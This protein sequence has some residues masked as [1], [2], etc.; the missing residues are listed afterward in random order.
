[1]KK[2]QLIIKKYIYRLM[3]LLAGITLLGVF[4][5]K[6]ELE[7]SVYR[8]SEI[9]M[10]DEYMEV[11]ANGLTDFLSLVDKA[12]YRGMLHAYGTYTCFVPT[13]NAVQEF[14]REKGISLESISEEEA[15]AF[16]GIHVVNDTLATSDFVDGRLISAT[17]RNQYLTV[18]TKNDTSG[19]VYIE[20][21]RQARIIEK[22]ISLGNGYIHVV[23][24]VLEESIQTVWETIKSLPDVEFSIMKELIRDTG[25]DKVLSQSGDSVFYSYFLQCNEVF[26]ELGV[27]TRSALLERLQENTPDITDNDA[28][29][30]NFVQYHC[31]PERK[32]VTD[33]LYASAFSTYGSN[34]VLTFNLDGDNIL[35]NEFKIGELDEDGVPVDRNSIYTDLT[36]FNGVI[37]EVLGQLEIKNRKA[38]RVYFDLA[39]QPEIRALKDF[40]KPGATAS[41]T[42]EDLSEVEFPALTLGYYCYAW[43]DDLRNAYAYGDYLDF[44]ISTANLSWIEFTTPLLVEGTYN[45]WLCTR[46]AVPETS[47]NIRASFKQTGEEDQIM[48][49]VNL[50][51]DIGSGL[52]DGV[53][54]DDKLLQENKKSY[55]TSPTF[56]VFNTYHGSLLG[57]IR[58]SSTGR[59][60]L[61]MDALNTPRATHFDMLQFIPVDEDQVWPKVAGDGT[62]VYK[63]TPGCEIYPYTLE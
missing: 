56:Q 1:M 3:S 38:Y 54:D 13:N 45:V 20:V 14:L 12:D 52:T 17:I 46:R 9:P 7:G 16:V 40:R 35:I 30:L 63:N 22:D 50:Y 48:N 29:L 43:T 5:C 53:P 19:E 62:W 42:N 24:H 61:R 59:H 33:M 32:Y 44:R 57:T 47:A 18:A 23:D 41:F 36:C 11:E 4:S 21:N 55:T 28:L 15:Q 6:D 51:N 26:H 49:V 60:I 10:I 37:H 58:V 27:D 39:D 8:T 2:S 31:V 34:Q 25:F